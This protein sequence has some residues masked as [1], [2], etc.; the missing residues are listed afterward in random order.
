MQSRTG[1]IL[2]KH[3][4]GHRV[5][6]Q[7]IRHHTGATAFLFVRM[8]LHPYR[9]DHPRLMRPGPPSSSYG[10]CPHPYELRDLLV[11]VII[12]AVGGDKAKWRKALGETENLAIAFHAQS[13]WAVH[14]TVVAPSKSIADTQM[15]TKPLLSF[16]DLHGVWI[17]RR[18]YCLPC[19][20]DREQ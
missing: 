2:T 15:V 16:F 7:R 10:Q 14:P 20:P 13:N 4:K 8:S 1:G 11:Q 19:K 12:G 9:W 3:G 6:T 5:T 17:K 18:R